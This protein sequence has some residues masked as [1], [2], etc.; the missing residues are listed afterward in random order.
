MRYDDKK[1]KLTPIRDKNATP[2]PPPPGIKTSEQ[3]FAEADK[4]ASIRP[5]YEITI[6]NKINE[7][8]KKKRG[9]KPSVIGS[10]LEYESLNEKSVL[11]VYNKYQGGKNKILEYEYSKIPVEA[12]QAVTKSGNTIASKILDAKANKDKDIV[13]ELINQCKMRLN[14]VEK[15]SVTA[16]KIRTGMTMLM[17][18]AIK[19]DKL[20]P[21]HIQDALDN[22]IITYRNLKRLGSMGVLKEEQLKM[23][24]KVQYKTFDGQTKEIEGK[25]YQHFAEEESMMVS[26]AGGKVRSVDKWLAKKFPNLADGINLHDDRILYALQLEEAGIDLPNKIPH[27]ELINTVNPSDPKMVDMLAKVMAAR[28]ARETNLDVKLDIMCDLVALYHQSVKE[29]RA[30]QPDMMKKVFEAC[31][32]VMYEKQTTQETEKSQENFRDAVHYCHKRPRVIQHLIKE[33]SKSKA[34]GALKETDVLLSAFTFDCNQLSE[35]FSDLQYLAPSHKQFE[36]SNVRKAWDG[37]AFT[38]SKAIVPESKMA[39]DF[40]E[41]KYKNLGRK[42]AAAPDVKES[43]MD[44][45]DGEAIPVPPTSP[46]PDPKEAENKKYSHFRV[47]LQTTTD[48]P[49]PLVAPPPEDS[50]QDLRESVEHLSSTAT[51]E[52]KEQ[53]KELEAQIEHGRATGVTRGGRE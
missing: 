13:T 11:G 10:T 15:D 44:W 29:N 24:I 37:V 26:K 1:G 2:A 48:A 32:D 12:L 49:A 39:Q 45:K 43:G 22:G 30:F 34:E 9:Y 17:K 27:M 40:Q 33:G 52:T 21:Q 51:A 36:G 8:Y 16:A 35:M 5:N 19:L 50:V 20:K 6:N 4:G 38:F 31:Q 18:D 3:K 23:N 41:F 53:A 28:I 46:P 25:L 14:N 47:K 42:R 7:Y